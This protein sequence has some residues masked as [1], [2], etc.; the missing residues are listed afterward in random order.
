MAIFQVKFPIYS[1]GYITYF[2]LGGFRIGTSMG[3]W[4]VKIPQ[5]GVKEMLLTLVQVVIEK[6]VTFI[7]FNPCIYPCIYLGNLLDITNM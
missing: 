5:Q 1:S 7:I 2:A 4:M 6:G 3:D